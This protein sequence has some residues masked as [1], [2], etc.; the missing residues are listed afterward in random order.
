MANEPQKNGNGHEDYPG[1]LL[2]LD[3]PT[4]ETR[5]VHYPE[6]LREP[7]L[8]LS[9]Y[10]RED[11]GRDLDILTENA[12]KLKIEFDKTTWSK[13]LRGRWNRNAEN[14]EVT[15][16]VNL[17]K[18]LNA[19]KTLRADVK[20]K[21]QA[22]AVPFVM[23][24]TAQTIFD[25]ITAL[26]ATN[27]VNKFG[28]IVGRT[29]TQKTAS[30]K[31]YCRRNNHLAC[32]HQEAPAKPSYSQFV[33]DIAVKY[34]S[35]R[36]SHWGKMLNLI[37]ESVNETRTIVI[38]NVQRLYVEKAQADQPVFNF[39]QK[40][41]DETGCTIVLTITPVFADTLTKKLANGY[42]EQF[43]GRAGGVQEFLRLPDFAPEEDVLKIAQSF[44]LQQADKHLDYLVK[45]SQEP[46]LIRILF[47]TLQ[48]AKIAA[49]A[50]KEKLTIQHVREARGED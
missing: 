44:G 24:S 34:G 40:L 20:L 8:W 2:K 43:I 10:I 25:F 50:A 17:A 28:I 14:A 16:I 13:V 27:R 11:C 45:V 42:F 6:D 4:M 26:R 46:G 9:S 30:T 38:E 19:I 22:G 36:Q 39:L 18:L 29:G 47:G 7:V 32:I 41:Q 23:T 49:E 21:Q 3:V 15:P 31:E 5:V 37:Y 35:A 12:R 1:G 33:T 48:K